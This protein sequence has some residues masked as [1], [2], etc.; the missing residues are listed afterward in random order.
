M[1]V[2][3]G[4]YGDNLY[5]L[6]GGCVEIWDHGLVAEETLTDDISWDGMLLRQIKFTEPKHDKVF[7]LLAVLNEWGTPAQV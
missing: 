4:E 3:K 6:S 2:R 7:G 5:I 1:Q